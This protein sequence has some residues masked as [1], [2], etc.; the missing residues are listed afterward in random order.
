MEY[1]ETGGLQSVGPSSLTVEML[2]FRELQIMFPKKQ[3]RLSTR[4][5]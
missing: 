5:L 3:T 4:A 1:I 2:V